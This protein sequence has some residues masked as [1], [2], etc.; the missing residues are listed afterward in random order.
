[1]KNI[2]CISG[3]GADERVFAKLKID[4]AN[5]IYLPWAP[6]DK[7][8]SLEH[9]AKKMASQIPEQNPIVMGLSFGGML[10][11]EIAKFMNVEHAILVS[12]S[13]T[14][15]EFPQYN[16]LVRYIIMHDLIPYKLFRKPNRMAYKQFGITTEEG[17]QL[18][19]DLL[20]DANPTLM[21]RSL[22]S[23]INW[24]NEAVPP[25]ITH[26]H[27]TN[28]LVIPGKAV[29][30]DYWIEGGSHMMIYDRAEEISKIISTVL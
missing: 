24:Q 7:N 2:Y 14:K 1:M 5:L 4:N 16:F 23:I 6:I 20:H 22:Q 25:K 28:D 3:L 10:T 29:K 18:L 17:K 19:K 26:I 13:K 27:G 30:A 21:T 9:Y 12:S 15:H 8:E 11:T